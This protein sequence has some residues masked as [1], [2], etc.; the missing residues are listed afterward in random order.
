[1]PGGDQ[2]IIYH[3][4]DKR[5]TIPKGYLHEMGITFYFRKLSDDE[6]IKQKEEKAI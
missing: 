1:M 4:Q 2:K 5:M 3:S 6:K